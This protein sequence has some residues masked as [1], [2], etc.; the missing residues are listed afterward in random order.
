MKHYD[1]LIASPGSS[2]VAGYVQS[3]AETLHGCAQRNLT[4]KF[5][6]GQSSLVHHARELTASG[7]STKELD[8]AQTAPGKDLTYDTI[9]WIDSDIS[10]TVEDFFRLVDS[11]YAVT[12][13][14]YLLNDGSTTVHAW[15]FPGSIPAHAMLSMK[16]PTKIQ[17]CGFGF[18]AMKQGVFEAMPRPWFSHEFQKVGVDS[19]GGDVIDCLGEDIS[20]CVKANRAKIDIWFDPRVLVTHNK[21]MPLQFR[22]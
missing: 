1:I 3:L 21:M 17:S 10:W 15:N 14:A 9:V 5:M 22:M 18:I 20:W 6:N 12:T 19:K 8:S 2:F 16:E 7:G 13:G 4:V 11:P